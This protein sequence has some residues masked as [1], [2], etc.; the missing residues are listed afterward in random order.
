MKPEM[1]MMI[2]FLAIPALLLVGADCVE[3]AETT[4]RIRVVQQGNTSEG[5]AGATVRVV[6]HPQSG[7]T[8]TYSERRT[9]NAEGIALFPGVVNNGIYNARP[10]KRGCADADTQTVVVP[11]NRPG[12]ATL[13]MNCSVAARAST[14]TVKVHQK[15]AS[16][17][18]VPGATVRVVRHPQ[19]Q[20]TPAFDERATTNNQG[21]A[22]FSTVVPNGTYNVR[23]SMTGCSAGAQSGPF[24]V[25]IPNNRGATVSMDLNCRIPFPRRGLLVAVAQKG[26]Y[27]GANIGAW[28]PGASVRVVNHPQ[29]ASTPA[30][31]RTVTTDVIGRALFPD[32]VSNGSYNVTVTKRRCRAGNL[33]GPRTVVIPGNRGAIHYADIDCR[34]GGAGIRP[35]RGSRRR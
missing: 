4:L 14:L 31:D 10:S 22:V 18:M 2:A 3:A 33:S 29:S 26:T 19:S 7:S 30:Y 1:P 27:N 8:P 17:A 21:Q 35:P 20:V 32:A 6:K 13:V 15:G 23:V 9:T 5:I 12:N 11:G 28:V 25:V 24:T 16:N 34:S